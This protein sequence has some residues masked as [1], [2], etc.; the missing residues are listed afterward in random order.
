MF[1]AKKQLKFFSLSFFGG[2]PL[3]YYKEIAKPLIDYISTVSKSKNVRFNVHF[4][5]NGFLLN[6]AMIEYLKQY[7]CSFQITFDG[8]RPLH[9]KTRFATLGHGS[10][11]KILSNVAKLTNARIHAVSRINF[12]TSNKPPIVQ[13]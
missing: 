11:D 2:E 4:T 10:Y 7:D 8:H 9:D 13:P 12:T 3:L 5:S 1:A 6:D